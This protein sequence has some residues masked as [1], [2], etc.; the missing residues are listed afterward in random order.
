MYFLANACPEASSYYCKNRSTPLQAAIYG[1]NA[2]NMIDSI[3]LANPKAAF[4]GRDTDGDLPFDL[5]FRHWNACMRIAVSNQNTCYKVLDNDTGLGGWKIG[6]VY[7]K[8]CLLLNAANIHRKG[9]EYDGSYFLHSALRE[10]SC[11]WAFCKLLMKLHPNEVL[12]RDLEGNLP[13]HIICAST[14]LSEKET[15]LCI[16]CYMPKSPLVGMELDDGATKY[17]C[18]DCFEFEPMQPIINSFYL[19]PGT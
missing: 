5:F 15:F 13:I 18:E 2:S 3:I 1:F 9:K 12:Q 16:D 10:E 4:I 8:S 17:C 6:D 19:R 14:Q 11:H 7:K